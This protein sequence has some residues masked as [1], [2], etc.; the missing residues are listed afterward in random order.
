MQSQTSLD[1]NAGRARI[2][3]GTATAR[4]SLAPSSNTRRVVRRAA[5]ENVAPEV[6]PSQRHDGV[7]VPFDPAARRAALLLFGLLVLLRLVTLAV[8][9]PHCLCRRAILGVER[10]LC[11]LCAEHGHRLQ[12]VDHVQIPDLNEGR[13]RSDRQHVGPR[14]SGGFRVQEKRRPRPEVHPRETKR[15]DGQRNIMV[16]VEV[17]VRLLGLARVGR[18]VA[19]SPSQCRVPQA[20]R[21]KAGQ[22]AAVPAPVQGFRRRRASVG[23][24]RACSSERAPIKTRSVA[25]S[26]KSSSSE[27]MSSSSFSDRCGSSL[28]SE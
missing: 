23:W 21:R 25:S 12:H 4:A 2:V 14:R 11:T 8:L 24:S 20:C 6:S 28:G 5:G 13:E 15:E 22:G 16:R 17:V 10:G 27:S 1:A 18:T 19:N 3:S 7:R 9:P 26:V